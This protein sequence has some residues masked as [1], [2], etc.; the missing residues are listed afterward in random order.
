MGIYVYN[1]ILHCEMGFFYLNDNNHID[2]DVC[3]ISLRR[4]ERS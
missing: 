4:N 3:Q 2:L 1:S